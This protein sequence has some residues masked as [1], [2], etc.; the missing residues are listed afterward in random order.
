MAD[1]TGLRN[2]IKTRA[3]F[4]VADSSQR[5]RQTLQATSPARSNRMKLNTKVDHRG[6]TATVQVAVPYA[7]YVREGTRAGYPIRPKKGKY[8]AFFWPNDNRKA[9]R[10]LPDG[11]ALVMSVTHPGIKAN[12][13]YND[14]LRK[15]PD[16]LADS[17]RRAP[18]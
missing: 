13:W 5:L 11:R 18:N 7:S 8:L 3:T 9:K 1:L 15:W 12:P 4:A 16:F 17:L 6:T 14:A 2:R 10:R